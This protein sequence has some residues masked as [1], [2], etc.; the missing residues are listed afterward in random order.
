MKKTTNTKPEQRQDSVI[1][2]VTMDRQLHAWLKQQAGKGNVAEYIR[3][4]ISGTEY[5]RNTLPSARFRWELAVALNWVG[6]NLQRLTEKIDALS[7]ILKSNGQREAELIAFSR[8]VE[9]L[10][11]CAETLTQISKS[12]SGKEDGNGHSGV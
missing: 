12:L 7:T 3:S 10:M 5:S 9:R 2:K 1:V 11:S 6:N 4:K 8:I